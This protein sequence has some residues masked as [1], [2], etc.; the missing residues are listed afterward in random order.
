MCFLGCKWSNRLDLTYKVLAGSWCH[1]GVQYCVFENI[2]IQATCVEID[3]K[4]L[5]VIVGN[6]FIYHHGLG[7]HF[8]S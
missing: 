3:C 7:G 6:N 5:V 4:F 1:N 2:Y 8:C